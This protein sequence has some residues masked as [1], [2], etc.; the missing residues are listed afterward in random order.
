MEAGETGEAR[1]DAAP[2]PLAGQ[3]VLVT[4]G[5]KGIG[6]RM[7][8][9]LAAQGAMVVSTC[10]EVTGEVKAAVEAVQPSGPGA[11]EAVGC[12]G[13]SS[14]E[15]AQLVEGRLADLGGVDVLINNAAIRLSSKLLETDPADLIDIFT[16]NVLAPFHFWQQVIPA[17][18][19]GGRGG[20][21]IDMIS[22]NAAR[23]P[24]VGMA[25]YRMSK[26]ALT[27]L[28]ADL[29]HEL[30]GS[31]IAVNALDPGPVVSPGTAAIR[32]E[33]SERY[34]QVAHH[35]QDPVEV[36]DAPITWLVSLRD[37]S[38]TGQVLRRQEFGVTWG[39]VPTTQPSTEGAT[40]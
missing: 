14:T 21:V 39:P 17:M 34:G 26:I 33:R 8:A 32:R 10:R 16:A 4:G 7:A 31:G 22:T 1:A 19:R 36:I 20:H 12:D 38:F 37:R 15:V 11:V 3:L 5:S 30:T 23:Q 28:S 27:S 6:L 35:E 18:Q 9:C 29:A 24:F 13:R 2:A 25:P 40:P